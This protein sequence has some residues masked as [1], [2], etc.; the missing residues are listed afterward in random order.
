MAVMPL[1]VMVVSRIGRDKR[2]EKNLYVHHQCILMQV[3]EEAGERQPV[4]RGRREGE[5]GRKERKQG[6]WK[7]DTRRNRYYSARGLVIQLIKNEIIS[8]N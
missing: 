6:C 7:N 1:R 5:K 3:G 8:F 2:E 4:Q